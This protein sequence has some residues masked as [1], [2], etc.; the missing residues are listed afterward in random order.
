MELIHTTGAMLLVIAIE[1]FAAILAYIDPNVGGLLF[2][3]LASIFGA[4]TAAFF[5]FSRQIR[6]GIAR[7]R[8]MIRK[9]EAPSD[10][11]PAE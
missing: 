9:E 11:K 5:F 7:L 1:S 2:T 6:A 3:V 8:R 4:I 10:E